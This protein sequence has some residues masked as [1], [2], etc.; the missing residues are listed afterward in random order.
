[1]E[2]QRRPPSCRVA[3]PATIA[4]ATATFSDRI[5][6]GMDFG[7]HT[8][9]LAANEQDIAGIIAKSRAGQARLGRQQDEVPA[10]GA[11]PFL[12]GRP[13]RIA[14]DLDM[15]KVI[16]AGPAE[17]LIA[18]QKA[19]GF[20]NRGGKPEA[21][22]HPQYCARVLRNV[23]LIERHSQRRG[24]VGRHDCFRGLSK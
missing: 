21:G 24:P 10:S 9:R 23:R 13:M 1:M 16:H 6:G 7:R 4:A 20:D 2:R 5:G 15:G 3:S 22:A 8:G 12:E 19:G 11:A 17:M 14:G 18:R